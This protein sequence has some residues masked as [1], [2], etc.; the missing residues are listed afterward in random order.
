MS[1]ISI[2]T[3]AFNKEQ[4]IQFDSIQRELKKFDNKPVIIFDLRNNQGSNS[5][6][7]SDIVNKLFSKECANKARNKINGSVFVDWRVSPDNIEY[8]KL[9]YNNIQ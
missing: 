4:L 5:S 3:F 9:L 2:P 6:Y 1:W 7:G 8:M